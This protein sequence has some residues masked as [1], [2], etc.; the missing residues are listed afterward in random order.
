L[1]DNPIAALSS[2][3]IAISPFIP[4]LLKMRSMLRYA[5]ELSFFLNECLYGNDDILDKY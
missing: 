3:I 5:Y 4:V 1:S 2:L